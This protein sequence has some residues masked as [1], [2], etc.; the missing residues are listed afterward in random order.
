MP[1]TEPAS[2]GNGVGVSDRDMEVDVVR[3]QSR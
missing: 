1:G 2:M 3:D